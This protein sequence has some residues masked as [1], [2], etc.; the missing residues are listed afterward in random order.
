MSNDELL[1]TSQKHICAYHVWLTVLVSRAS[2]T[3]FISVASGMGIRTRDFTAA[4]FR[5][6][7]NLFVQTFSFCALSSIVFG[8][9]RLLV[10][11][12]FLLPELANG[13]VMVAC[14]PATI[15]SVAVLTK[16]G[17]GDEAAAIFNSA[18]ANFLGI[19]VSPILILGYLGVRAEVNMFEVFYTL[20][21][22]VI[23][24][25]LL[26]QILQRI[27]WVVRFVKKHRFAFHQSTLYGLVWIVYTV[28]CRTFM[29]ERVSALKDI[30]I[31]VFVVICLYVFLLAVAWYAL[32][33]A[34]RDKPKLRVMGMFGCSLKTV[35][36]DWVC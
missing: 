18:F 32:K 23:V 24:P 30:F 17:G 19:F 1:I 10:K 7:F 11:I 26:G 33:V 20:A 12:N 27:R 3:N 16:Q 35:S 28:F 14:V 22:R 21:L 8:V 29:G 15:N 13:L 31:M 34:F 6:K 2:F 36:G 4:M 5:M 25:V 9:T